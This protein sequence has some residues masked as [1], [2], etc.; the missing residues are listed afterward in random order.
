MRLSRQNRIESLLRSEFE[1]TYLKIINESANH[2]HG[3]KDGNEH[4]HLNRDETHMKVVVVSPK[5]VGLNRVRR[6]QLVYKILESLFD[7]GLHALSLATFTAEEWN[8]GA[9]AI[10][11][12]ACSSQDNSSS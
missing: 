7:E 5:F 2:R 12:P 10:E 1:P 4:E 6:Q 11:S 9:R 3:H 8:S